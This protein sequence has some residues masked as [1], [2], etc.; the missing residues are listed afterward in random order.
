MSR[1]RILP[2]IFLFTVFGA[3]AVVGGV[4]RDAWAG[5]RHHHDHRRSYADR[6]SSDLQLNAEQ[7]DSLEAILERRKQDMCA[8]WSDFRP[9]FD[10][11]RADV[12]A[13]IHQLLNET[14]QSDYEAM[15]HRSDSLRANRKDSGRGC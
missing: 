14:Q 2:V 13:E 4:V 3:G 1:G 5:N 12:R 8:L 7:E 15:I 6:L 10:S 11:M 9:R